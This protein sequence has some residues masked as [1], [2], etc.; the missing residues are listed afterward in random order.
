MAGACDGSTEAGLMN[1][2]R[3]L[4]RDTLPSTH[5]AGR[6]AFEPPCHPQ[7]EGKVSQTRG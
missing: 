3:V 4:R 7:T 1:A 5:E 6:G 2:W